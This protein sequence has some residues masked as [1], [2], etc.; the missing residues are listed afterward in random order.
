LD[1]NY[2]VEVKN[3]RPNIV[4]NSCGMSDEFLVELNVSSPS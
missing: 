2:R 3:A 1:L 4:G